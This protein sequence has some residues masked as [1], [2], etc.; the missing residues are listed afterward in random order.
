MVS[1]PDSD[2]RA[3]RTPRSNRLQTGLP[4]ESRSWT[5]QRRAAVF[6]QIPDS[7][8]TER[9]VRHL[10]ESV[11]VHE[12][13]VTRCVPSAIRA[14]RVIADAFAT[15]HKLMLCGNGGSAADCQHIAAEF[16]NRLRAEVERAPLPAI[17]LTTDTSVLT[18]YANDYGYDG[19]F[20]RQVQGLG[21]SGDVLWAITTSGGSKNVAEAINAANVAGM[22]TV[23]LFGRG[24]RLEREVDVA[25]TVPSRS[26][27]VIQECMLSMEHIICELVE[28]ELFGSGNRVGD[29]SS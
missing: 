14:V 4:L 7:A 10:R 12:L 2:G 3:L 29:G 11:A 27:Q 20:A 25:I 15:G 13:S 18:A 6:D 16:V 17:A 23:G 21:N 8:A 24:G 19:V 1:V 5:I 26:T 28:E 9:A 22:R